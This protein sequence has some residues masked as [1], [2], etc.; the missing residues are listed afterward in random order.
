MGNSHVINIIVTEP[1]WRGSLMLRTPG[2]VRSRQRNVP[3]SW[4]RVVYV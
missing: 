2:I 1:R 3:L 4:Y